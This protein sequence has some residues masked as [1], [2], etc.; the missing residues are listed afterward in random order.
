[1]TIYFTA[2]LFKTGSK[3]KKNSMWNKI[4]KNINTR[5]KLNMCNIGNY[6]KW[7]TLQT[8]SSKKKRDRFEYENI[9][10]CWSFSIF[11]S[12][13]VFVLMVAMFLLL[14]L[15]RFFL[16]FIFFSLL[17][18]AGFIRFYL[19][20]TTSSFSF[21]FFRIN[22]S[23]SHAYLTIGCSLNKRLQKKN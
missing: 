16:S 21:L 18:F 7:C 23:E 8:I 6:C 19:S 4:T 9:S 5:T 14:L 17:S 12:H 13:L 10:L 20:Q 15:Y 1:M 11:F 22:R 2:G 3:K